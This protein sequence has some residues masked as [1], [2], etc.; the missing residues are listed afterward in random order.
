LGSELWLRSL[1]KI[2]KDFGDVVGGVVGIGFGLFLKRFTAPRRLALVTF[3][4]NTSVSNFHNSAA[5][6][7]IC[8]TSKFNSV[9]IYIFVWNRNILTRFLFVNRLS[10]CHVV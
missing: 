4:P 6:P 8:P 5:F 7:V 10:I 1:I 9:A 3:S 2:L